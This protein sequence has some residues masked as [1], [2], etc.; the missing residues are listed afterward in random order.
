[1]RRALCRFIRLWPI[2]TVF[3]V[4]PARYAL[5]QG[6]SYNGEISFS[7]ADSETQLRT[8]GQRVKSDSYTIE[9]RHNLNLTKIIYP[10]LTFNTGMYFDSINSTTKS[11]GAKSELEDRTLRPFVGLNL[12]NPLYQGGLTYR[13]IETNQVS[14]QAP[15]RE[16]FQD[17]LDATLGWT[18]RELPQVS[19]HYNYRHFNDH[20]ET[21]DTIDKL[22]QVLSSYTPWRELR[23]DYNYTRADREDRVGNFNTLEQTHFARINYAQGFWDG[24]LA[25][26]GGYNIWYDTLEFPGGG[27]GSAE[28][29]VQRTQGLFSLDNTPQ[30]GPA[31]AVNDALIDGNL[32]AS[33]GINLG[34]N[35]DQT[36]LANIGLDFGVAVDVDQIRL[37]VDR[38]LPTGISD[39]FSWSVYTSPDNTNLSTWT[40]VATVFPADF[41]A[42]EN[43]FEIN[44]AKVNTRFIKVVTAALS[45]LVPGS[46]NFPDIF[47]T[48]MQAFV[49]VSQ[50][51]FQNKTTT[52][53]QNANLG[54]RARI[55][56]DTTVGYNVNYISREQDPLNTKSTQ[57]EN[58]LFLNHIINRIFSAGARFA[59]TD[60]SEDH[61]DT[62]TYNYN[63]FV[64]GAYLPTFDQ[65]LT[66]SGTNLSEEDD[67]SDLFTLLLHNNAILYRGWSAFLDS[68]LNYNRPTGSDESERSVLLRVGTNFEPNRKFTL[69]LNYQLRQLYRPEKNAQADLN[70]DAFFVPT[71]TLSFNANFSLVERENTKTTTYQN[72]AVNWSPSPDGDLQFFFVYNETL[73]SESNDRRTTIGPGFNWTVSNHFYLEMFYNYT[74][75][76]S[77]TLK[78]ESNNVFA[79]LRM[80]F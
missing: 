16:S 23:L 61:E 43:R 65:T 62:V 56:E 69:N 78:V 41:G 77:N 27:G 53:D 30:D 52:T 9:Q 4:L 2:I 46:N 15:N 70:V 11:E 20:P 58:T 45:P 5:A 8:T 73:N 34:L 6:L 68:G 51:A 35:G 26:N 48:E 21:F 31:L 55:T 18:P 72:Y 71:R 24:R 3:S 79:K 38:T 63:A 36:T 57:L 59:R 17:E 12:T 7:A 29:S 32:T 60:A 33:A 40:L 75:E 64:K 42:F 67:S 22:L 50:G 66:F 76:R 28:V 19:L 1:M 80:N 14:P 39:S 37:W 54:L 49:T 13:R 74:R 47:V 10:Y 25:V 44:F